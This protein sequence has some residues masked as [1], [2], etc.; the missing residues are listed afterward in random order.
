M[1]RRRKKGETGG[2]AP[3]APAPAE[4]ALAWLAGRRDRDGTPLIDKVERAAGERL[5]ADVERANRG[6]RTT[7][8][9]TGVGDRPGSLTETQRLTAVEAALSARHRVERALAALEPDFASLVIDVCC[10]E[11]GLAEV[12]RRRGWPLRSAKLMLRYALRAL[13]RHYG[14]L[15]AAP[16]SSAGVRH[17]GAEDFRPRA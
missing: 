2:G 13:S 11:V 9:W 14:L 16:A 3:A 5:L 17:W 10:R 6:P 4:G 12:E 1:T 7:M 8:D 15:G